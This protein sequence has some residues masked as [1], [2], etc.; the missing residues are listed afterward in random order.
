[1]EKHFP[2]KPRIFHSWHTMNS[3]VCKRYWLW[4]K[5][6]ERDCSFTIHSYISFFIIWISA[7]LLHSLIVSRSSSLYIL[8]IYMWIITPC[9]QLQEWN[10]RNPL[11]WCFCSLEALWLFFCIHQPLCCSR[12]DKEYEGWYDFPQR[13]INNWYRR[14]SSYNHSFQKHEWLIMNIW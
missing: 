2:A 6:Q 5:K 8:S 3:W 14:P 7:F 4:I 12:Q 13:R 1:M 10:V 11:I 9:F